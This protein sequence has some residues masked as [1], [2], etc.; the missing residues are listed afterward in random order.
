MSNE[1][2]RLVHVDYLVAQ[3]RHPEEARAAV[4]AFHEKLDRVGHP[5]VPAEYLHWAYEVQIWKAELPDGRDEVRVSDF[6]LRL[7]SGSDTVSSYIFR[8][9]QPMDK[10]KL[11]VEVTDAWERELG[12]VTPENTSHD[13][14]I[15]APHIVGDRKP[16]KWMVLGGVSHANGFE[17]LIVTGVNSRLPPEG[18]SLSLYVPKHSSVVGAFGSIEEGFRNVLKA[19]EGAEVRHD[20]RLYTRLTRDRVLEISDSIPSALEAKQDTTLLSRFLGGWK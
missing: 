17:A 5:R 2:R 1:N 13:C 16:E 12:G 18:P 19:E 4:T 14:I 7:S 8:K 6:G 9:W 3:S 15:E 20:N 10:A 11:P